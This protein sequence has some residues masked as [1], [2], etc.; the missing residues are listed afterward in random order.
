MRIVRPKIGV[1]CCRQF[2]DAEKI[3]LLEYLI[4][5]CH[6]QSYSPLDFKPYVRPIYDA[7]LARLA[8][9]DQD[10]VLSR[11]GVKI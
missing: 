4:I 5:H 10:Q 9:Q 1:I 7:I 11:S 6:L 2:V 8:N 3:D